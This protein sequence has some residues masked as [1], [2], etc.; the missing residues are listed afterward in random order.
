MDRQRKMQL[1]ALATTT[2]NVD[3][4]CAHNSSF[5]ERGHERAAEVTTLSRF[6]RNGKFQIGDPIRYRKLECNRLGARD[7][8]EPPSHLAASCPHP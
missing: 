1:E 4:V 3:G 8:S 2:L 6:G 5:P 7:D